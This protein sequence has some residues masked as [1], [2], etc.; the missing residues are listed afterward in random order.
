MRPGKRLVR[1]HLKGIKIVRRRRVGGYEVIYRY[2]RASG[3]LLKGEPNTP[4]FIESYAAACAAVKAR[5]T[6]TL[7]ALIRRFEATATFDDL[8][9]TTKIEYRRKFKVID[10][11]WGTCPIAA[12]EDREFRKDVLSWRDKIALRGR[13]EADNLV[14][15]LARVLAFGVDRAELGVNVLAHVERVY[16]S[17]RSDKIWLPEHIDAFLKVAQPELCA[18]LMLAL[19][20]GQR[21]G[22]LLRLPWSAYDGI[23][24]TLI[25][26]KGKRRVE[27]KCTGALRGLLDSLPRRGPLILTTRTGRAWKK[28]Y[29][30]E[31]WQLATEAAGIV[32]LHFHDLR[33]T[34]VTMLF[35]AGCTVAEV[36]SVSGH[37]LAHAQRILDAYLARTRHL[38]D[39]AILKFEER[40]THFQTRT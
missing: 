7:G 19:H 8:A 22:D 13:R 33:G 27:I 1:V 25:Q 36:A 29:F 30:A 2:H 12:L 32:D 26:G 24:I 34:A 10:R 39:A 15:A 11:D 5:S 3:I 20:S 23:R 4:E 14:S 35:E 21:Q 28:R 18:A 40:V 17:E 6:G 38:A 9:E 16:R 31:Q 37:S